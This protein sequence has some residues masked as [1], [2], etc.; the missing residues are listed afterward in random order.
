M[1]GQI[2]IEM[3][4]V[5]AA[6]LAIAFILVTQLQKTATNAG[7]MV[8][9]RSNAILGIGNQS[10]NLLDKGAY[11]TSS[12]QCKSKSCTFNICD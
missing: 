10:S 4:L 7:A 2:S 11:C 9:N 1:K 5:L 3:I 8:E 6:I 12:Q